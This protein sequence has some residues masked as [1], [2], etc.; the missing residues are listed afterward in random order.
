M[1]VAQLDR[2]HYTSSHTVLMSAG[3]DLKQTIGWL[4]RIESG[5]PTSQVSPAAKA[6]RGKA[7]QAFLD[8]VR[9]LER[10]ERA[11]EDD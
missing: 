2:D 7:T 5:L 6:A 11:V 4:K 3:R 9:I 1:R 10:I 8:V